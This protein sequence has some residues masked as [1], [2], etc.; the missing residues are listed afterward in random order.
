[1][2]GEAGDAY[3]RRRRRSWTAQE[4]LAIVLEAETSAAP[5]AEVARRHGLN[6]N[7]LFNW[8]QRYRDGTLDRRGLRERLGGPAADRPSTADGVDFLALGLVG[9]SRRAEAGAS[10]IEIELPN[11]TRIRVGAHVDAEALR[12]V[13]AALTG[14][15]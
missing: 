1:M 10:V 15:P 3:R 9:D 14:A 4:K 2:I 11:R 8:R 13:L 5:V 7:H 12:R 6:A